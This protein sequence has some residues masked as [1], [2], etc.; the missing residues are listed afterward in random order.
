MQHYDN[1]D[2]TLKPMKNPFDDCDEVE[3]HK[4]V[5]WHK[6]TSYFILHS[7]LTRRRWLAGCNANNWPWPKALMGQQAAAALQ[8]RRTGC[9]K[10]HPLLV[11]SWQSV[12]ASW[13]W[14]TR[15]VYEWLVHSIYKLA[16]AVT[17]IS[18]KMDGIHLCHSHLCILKAINNK[19]A[20]Q[21]ISVWLGG[22][23]CLR[24]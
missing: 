9:N 15:D 1:K 7:T 3:L 12:V 18:A 17:F 10:T 2:R 6:K 23:F 21:Y 16:R 5:I 8:R 4:I 19:W 13:R 20:A 14:V 24:E 11:L 22:H